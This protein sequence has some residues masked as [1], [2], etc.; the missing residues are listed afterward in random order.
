MIKRTFLL[1]LVFLCSSV[2]TVQA[3]FFLEQG[4]VSLTVSS[5]ERVA[6]TL[7]VNNTTNESVPVRVYWEDFDYQAPYDGSKIFLPA[8]TG[9]SSASN[10]INYSPTEFTLPPFGKQTIDY[11]VSVPAQADAGHYGVMFFERT[12]D[13]I[14]D[15]TGVQIVTRVGSLFFIEPKDASRNAVV[16][17]IK[18]NEDKISGNFL[19]QSQVVLIPRMTYYVMDQEGL[20]V[21]RGEVKKIYVPPGATAPWSIA[22][23]KTVN[24]GQFTLILNTD[25]EGGNVVVKEIDFQK[26]AAGTLSIEKIRD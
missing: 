3:Q 7:V 15:A 26:D 11:V 17:E 20:V 2:G 1:I 13:P 24:A 14:K 10:W 23:S 22:L 16:D 4:K 21:D 6:K 25:L 12:G 5:G 8:G 18:I 19:N 9:K